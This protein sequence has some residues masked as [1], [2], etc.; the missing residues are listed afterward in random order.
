MAFDLQN[1]I[2]RDPVAITFTV[3][4]A[5]G[6]LCFVGGFAKHQNDETSDIKELK[7]STSLFVY[8][9]LA[10]A[11]LP[12]IVL[13]QIYGCRPRRW[14]GIIALFF[15]LFMLVCAGGVLNQTGTIIHNCADAHHGKLKDCFFTKNSTRPHDPSVPGS[16]VVTVEPYMQAEFAGVFLYSI[17]QSLSLCLYF[18][19]AHASSESGY[20]TV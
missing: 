7:I 16:M 2:K 8:W 14:M 12:G 1:Q 10:L 18:F 3:L 5:L 15:C 17:F 19:R 4:A 6:W 20:S 11:G 13:I 9:G